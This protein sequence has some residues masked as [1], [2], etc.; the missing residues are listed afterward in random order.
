MQILSQVSAG[1]G[2]LKA[3]RPKEPVLLQRVR[4]RS[5]VDFPEALPCDSLWMAGGIKTSNKLPGRLEGMEWK[6]KRLYSSIMAP[7]PPSSLPSR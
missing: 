2:M 4:A 6:K 7:P 5:R 1:Q 3:F